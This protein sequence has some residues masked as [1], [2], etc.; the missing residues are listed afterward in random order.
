MTPITKLLVANRGAS[1]ARV[2]WTAQGMGIDTVAGYA[3]PSAHAPFVALADEAARLP[4]ATVI[5]TVDPAAAERGRIPVADQ[6]RFSVVVVG[7]LGRCLRSTSGPQRSRAHATRRC[8]FGNPV[9]FLERVVLDSCHVD[10]H[11]A[12]VRRRG[13]G[14]LAARA[15]ARIGAARPRGRRRG[16]Q[17]MAVVESEEATG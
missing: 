11:G 7:G 8:A 13:A 14:R 12:A 3:D 10:V 15:D 16:R 5:G 4:S 6:G 2:V 9:V 1:A 17:T